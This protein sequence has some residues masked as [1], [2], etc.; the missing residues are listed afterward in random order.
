LEDPK[1]PN[2]SKERK[3]QAA[4]DERILVN[5]IVG[6]FGQGKRRFS[7]AASMQN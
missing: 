3:K 7:L 2:V 1:S 4:Y 6:M 5:A